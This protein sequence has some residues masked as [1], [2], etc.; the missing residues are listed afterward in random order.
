MDLTSPS[1][2]TALRVAGCIIF[3]ALWPMAAPAVAATPA[4]LHAP[5]L[6]PT[7]RMEKEME[8]L[9]RELNALAQETLSIGRTAD[10]ARRRELLR[11]HLTHLGD[12]TA[13]M[14]AM[15][16]RMHT[17]LDSG[18]IAWDS[19]A[20]ERHAFFLD[21]VAMTAVLVE[22]ALADPPTRGTDCK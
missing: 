13:R 7:T 18:R 10:P 20:R 16:S 19:G 1:L 3:L 17:A 12:V 9:R 21:Q 8:T 2:P 5:R 4:E 6:A 11:A 22:S 14:R 15:E